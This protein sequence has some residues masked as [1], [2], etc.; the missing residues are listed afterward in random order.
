[1]KPDTRMWEFLHEHTKGHDEVLDTMVIDRDDSLQWE[2]Y[3][4]SDFWRNYNSVDYS[5]D[6]F[7]RRGNK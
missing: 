5:P 3:T 6:G 1:M 4:W 2:W 7:M